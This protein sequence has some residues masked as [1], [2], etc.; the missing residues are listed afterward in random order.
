MFLCAITHS[1]PSTPF[2]SFPFSPPSLPKPRRQKN[3]Y[4]W[5]KE[6]RKLALTRA[7]LLL[8][9]RGGTVSRDDWA[10]L[11]SFL[12][13]DCD[14]DHVSRLRCLFC[15]MKYFLCLGVA[16]PCPSSHYGCHALL[17]P[18][19][20]YLNPTISLPCL[21]VP[22]RA[23]FSAEQTSALFDAA[24]KATRA[25]GGGGGDTEKVSKEGFFMLCAL[26][27]AKFSQ[28]LSTFLLL[29]LLLLR[30]LQ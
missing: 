25:P 24:N 16:W 21:D 12:R 20:P 22:F 9:Q 10:Q 4:T 1:L 27:R 3:S 18:T 6:Q 19:L 14:P 28:V 13:P 11:M 29:L 17:Y 30:L 23:V 7:Y 2:P 15:R 26:G 8:E 5:V